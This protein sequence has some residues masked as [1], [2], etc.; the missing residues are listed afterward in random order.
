MI[1]AREKEAFTPR[2]AQTAI[3]KSAKDFY[4]KIDTASVTF[5]TSRHLRSFQKTWMNAALLNRQA[6]CFKV[7]SSKEWVRNFS[8]PGWLRP[9]LLENRS[10]SFL[11]HASILKE[12]EEF[13]NEQHK[14]HERVK[15]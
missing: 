3:K 12:V 13:S 8:C 11:I 15:K 1:R 9:L 6:A 14:P 2:Q 4:S 10:N 7:A 5:D